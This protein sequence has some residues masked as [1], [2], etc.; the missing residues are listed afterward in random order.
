[1]KWILYITF[2]LFFLLIINTNR[3]EYFVDKEKE[4]DKDKEKEKEKEIKWDS[5]MES[6]WKKYIVFYSPFMKNWQ[7]TIIQVK[8]TENTPEEQ[9]SSNESSPSPSPPSPSSS[10]PSPSSSPPLPSLEEQNKHVEKLE[11]KENKDFSPIIDPVP[12]TLPEIT[13]PLNTIKQMNEMIPPDSTIF[14]NTLLWMNNNI[15][16]TLKSFE[17]SMKKAKADAKIEGYQ[18]EDVCQMVSKCQEQKAQDFDK[19]QLKWI[20]SINS[21]LND[22][23]LMEAWEKNKELMAKSKEIQKKALNGELLSAPKINFKPVK[24]KTL[25]A[26]EKK[27]YGSDLSSLISL[28]NTLDQIDGNMR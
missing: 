20:N 28:K 25:S 15:E 17:D 26:K 2:I 23:L 21:L 6:V 13:K 7:I 19:L 14:L 9:K 5:K 4:K 12:T 11:T 10:P 18:S 27:E 24:I 3:A 22:H 16:D 8:S 1:M